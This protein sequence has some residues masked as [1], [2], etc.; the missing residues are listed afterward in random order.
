[1]FDRIRVVGCAST[2]WLR[3]ESSETGGWADIFHGWP[4]TLAQRGG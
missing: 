3:V 1:M 4:K 2:T